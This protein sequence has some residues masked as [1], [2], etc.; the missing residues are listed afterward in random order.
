MN[1]PLKG[2]RIVDLGMYVAGPYASVPIAD[3]G[4][5]VI[6]IEPLTGD[7]NRVMWRPF[8]SCNRGKRSILIDLKQA[9]GIEIAKKICI[10]ADVVSHN[11]RPGVAERLGLGYEQLSKQNPGLTYM[12]SCAYGDTGPMSKMPGF[13]M[14]IQAM[15]GLEAHC[16]GEG[17]EPLWMRWAPVD[18]TCAYLSTIGM[19]AG[20]YQKLRSGKGSRVTTNLLDAGIFLFSELLRDGRDKASQLAQMNSS[21]TGVHPARSIYRTQDGW[22]AIVARTDEQGLA[23]AEALGAAKASTALPDDWGDEEYQEISTAAARHNNRDLIALLNEAGVWA[24]ACRDDFNDTLFNSGAWKDSGLLRE[25]PHGERGN[26]KQIGNCV[27]FS[28]ME[29]DLESSGRAAIPGEDTREILAEFDYSDAQ[30]DDL[31]SRNIVA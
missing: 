5:D 16:G 12:E 8:A 29:P 22:V 2:L 14:M 6:K 20:H 11:F 15:C 25:Y 19:M 4:A 18:F 30:I 7:P 9:G 28:G 26:I 17:N 1:A 10:A 23:L 3:L 21:M 27:R 24:E 13:D 31:Y